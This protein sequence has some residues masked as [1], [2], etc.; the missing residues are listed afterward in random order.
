MLTHLLVPGLLD[1]WPDSNFQRRFPLLE[2]LLARAGQ[3][4]AP[5]DYS[6]TL[7]SLL[8]MSFQPHESLPTAGLC[9][10]ANFDQPPP[11]NLLHADP[12]Y[13]KPDMSDVRLF[14]PENLN[15]QQAQAY[16]KAFNDFYAS[17]G[18]SMQLSTP[19]RWYISA[20]QSIDTPDL[21]LEQ[22][23]GRN[24]RSFVKIGEQ[25][26]EWNRL[27]TEIQMLFHDLPVNHARQTGGELPVSGVWLSGGGDAP[28][29]G[30][31]SIETVQGDDPLLHGLATHA[32]LSL[33]SE[34]QSSGGN[35]L[36]VMK[37]CQAA[38]VSMDCLAWQ[39]AVQRIEELLG[40]WID[41][42][43]QVILYPCNGR[44]WHWYPKSKY[45]LWRKNH[46]L[47]YYQV[48]GDR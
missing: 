30:S 17:H 24:L 11:A 31:H 41:N 12:V 7:F 20:T 5:N 46:G 27:F 42:R 33:A 23:T 9:W 4:P 6:R 36:V 37:D 19:N 32:G 39:D 40:K 8:E 10:L 26:R 18:L 1:L 47:T 35:Q 25:S 38:R 34:M 48:T 29:A 44:A 43:D 15:M 22:I 14:R 28:A 45:R 3:K 2:R 13:L 16:A 21:C